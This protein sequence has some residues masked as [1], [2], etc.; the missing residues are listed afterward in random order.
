MREVRKR[1]GREDCK[2]KENNENILMVS[3]VMKEEK[4]M[5]KKNKKTW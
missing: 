3:R 4:R 2:R 5:K 1:K